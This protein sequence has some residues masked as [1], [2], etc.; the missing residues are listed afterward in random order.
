MWCFVLVVEPSLNAVVIFMSWCIKKIEITNRCKTKSSEWSLQSSWPAVILFT[1]RWK[2]FTEEN[3]WMIEIMLLFCFL[4]NTCL[5]PAGLLVN[6]TFYWQITSS[7]KCFCFRG[8]VPTQWGFYSVPLCIESWATVSL[9]W[10]TTEMFSSLTL[11][12]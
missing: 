1:R 8:F 7:D 6:Y 5:P 10:N 3:C 2:L 4:K 12:R 11:W 9:P